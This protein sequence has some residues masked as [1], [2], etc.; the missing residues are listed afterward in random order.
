M[1]ITYVDFAHMLFFHEKLYSSFRYTVFSEPE[2]DYSFGY[3]QSAYF[4]TEKELSFVL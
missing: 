3:A 4:H 2:V 1:G